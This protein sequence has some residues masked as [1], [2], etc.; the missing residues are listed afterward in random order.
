MTNKLVS[1]TYSMK[2]EVEEADTANKRPRKVFPVSS[3]DINIHL[4]RD[5]L[6][7]IVSEELV[8]KYKKKALLVN[9]ESR[10][11]LKSFLTKKVKADE[12]D[13]ES[14]LTSIIESFQEPI[15][16]PDPDLSDFLRYTKRE[17]AVIKKDSDV[18]KSNTQQAGASSSADDNS[19]R[20]LTGIPPI[21][22]LSFKSGIFTF[23]YNSLTFN[24]SYTFAIAF[25]NC[26]KSSAT[27]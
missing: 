22:G 6:N 20:L 15:P 17:L 23:N 5:D 16:P 2:R 14:I 3:D 24:Q 7:L 13:V 1:T 27:R 8:E 19:T 26:T 25:P 4:K 11:N 21:N 18:I 10:D 12:D 9:F